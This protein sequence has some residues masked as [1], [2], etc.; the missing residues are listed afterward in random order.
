MKY[1]LVGGLGLAAGTLLLATGCGEDNDVL[2]TTP[3]TANVANTNNNTTDDG[4]DDANQ[5]TSGGGCGECPTPT[6]GASC[7]TGAADVTAYQAAAEGAC[8]LDL[9]AAFGF[10][11]CNQLGQPGELDD[12][13]PE[14]EYPPGSPPM[15]G[16][17]TEA[18]VC[19]AMEVA[20]GFGCTTNP[21][22]STHVACGG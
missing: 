11:G 17:C 13:C 15:A 2:Y 19:G 20:L 14:V 3:P 22:P 18:G 7:C 1:K 9:S 10:P 6:T 8:G 21:D 5:L 4:L 16:C 12:A